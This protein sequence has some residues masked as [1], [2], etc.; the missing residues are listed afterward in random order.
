MTVRRKDIEFTALTP[1]W[2][3][4]AEG[5]SDSRTLESGLIGS[6]RWWLEAL[7]RSKGVR[8]PDPTVDG[9]EEY[10]PEKK[11]GGLSAVSQLFGA[12]G[13]R[14]RFRLEVMKCGEEGKLKSRYIIQTGTP[15][16]R[17]KLKEG[18]SAWY[19]DS[20]ARAGEFRVRLTSL[21]DVDL[22]LLGG[23]MQFVAERGGLGAK[24]Q[25][26]CGVISMAEDA[27]GRAALEKWLG[28]LSGDCEDDLPRVDRMFFV[29]MKP[30]QGA[31]FDVE[32]PFRLKAELR[33][34]LHGAG[35]TDDFRHELMGWVKPRSEERIAAKV[36]ISFPYELSGGGQEMR[37]W[38]WVPKQWERQG[39]EMLGILNVGLSKLYGEVEWRADGLRG[40]QN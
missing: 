6:L 31:T 15:I 17:D 10:D 13:W 25:N 12:T 22:D 1:L 18:E 3:G 2:T 7:A 9:G 20:D 14:R 32:E 36:H 16:R 35:W 39:G 40:D 34:K 38:G 19:F 8:I 37:I 21:D 33:Q 11:D 26:G 4:D 23:L 30:K 27:Q 5:E 24:T 29:K 28:E